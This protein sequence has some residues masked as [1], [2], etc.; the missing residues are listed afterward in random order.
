M[1][2]LSQHFKGDKIYLVG[3]IFAVLFLGL[4]L[5]ILLA[6]NLL[7]QSLIP[8]AVSLLSP[9]GNV[10]PNGIN[11]LNSVLDLAAWVGLG[12]FLAIYTYVFV[13]RIAS[14][15][16]PASVHPAATIQL[17]AS[18]TAYLMIGVIIVFAVLIRLPHLNRGFYYDE[19]F[20]TYHF[21]NADSWWGTISRFIIFNNHILY[22]VL[23]RISQTIFGT[24]EWA[25]RLP[26]FIMGIGSIYLAWWFA[27]DKFGESIALAASFL[28]A[29]SPT[30]VL[31]SVSARG[32]TGLIFFSLLSTISFFSLLAKP[33]KGPASIY[34]LASVAAVYTHL[35]GVWLVVGQFFYLTAAAITT[36]RK[37][38]TALHISIGSFRWLWLSFGAITLLSVFCYLPVITQLL[39]SMNRHGGTSFQLLFPI[40]FINEMSGNIMLLGGVTFVLALLGGMVYWRVYPGYLTY[41]LSISAIPLLISWVVLRPLNLYARFFSNLMPFYLIL[42]CLGFQAVT[43]WIMRARVA[44]LKYALS[45]ILICLTGYAL[46]AWASNSWSNIPEEAQYRSAMQ[47]LTSQAGPE[48]TLCVFG[49]DADIFQFYTDE[50][51]V[52]P[53]TP[54]ELSDLLRESKELRCAYHAAPWNPIEL[55]QM[56]DMLRQRVAPTDF[57]RMPVFSVHQ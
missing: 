33:R 48:V 51:L 34:I 37:K 40:S 49:S 50:P 28:L 44:W 30:H 46:F 12:G 26:A 57:R 38:E 27:R 20:T 8:L 29:I 25:L 24:F 16:L 56:A 10:T 4:A 36:I 47:K 53:K 22:S 42:V 6:R 19:L 52:F 41:I 5:T 18:L 23:G 32:Y 2:M 13:L 9:D 21:I 55:T 45:G 1:G 54:A 11:R 15:R 43:R 31:W 17:P 35:H 7:S 3:T 14:N 39:Y